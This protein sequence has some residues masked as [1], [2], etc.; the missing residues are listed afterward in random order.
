MSYRNVL[1]SLL[2]CGTILMGIGSG[3]AFAEY[4]SFSYSG[5][6]NIIEDETTEEYTVNIEKYI[7]EDSDEIYF[8]C[9]YL[10]DVEV[11]SDENVKDNEM[12]VDVK[13]S[14]A[15]GKPFIDDNEIHNYYGSGG[16]LNVIDIGFVHDRSYSDLELMM[17]YKDLILSDIKNRVISDYD[18]NCITECIIKV[19]PAN[20]DKVKQL[21]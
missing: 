4:S 12:V 10:N 21:Y 19:S 18:T 2:I 14:K 1:V 5:H 15:F 6:S 16:G 3:I 20:A 7:Q 8:T 11:M 9:F 13:Y 17:K